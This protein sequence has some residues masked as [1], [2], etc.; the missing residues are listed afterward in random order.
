[1]TTRYFFHLYNGSDVIVDEI[2]VEVS[3]PDRVSEALMQA[4]R[5]MQRE[6]NFNGAEL[7]GWELGVVDSAGTGVMT[8]RL[9]DLNDLWTAMPLAPP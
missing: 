5:E 7:D 2:G 4:M 9:R 8:V 1:M 6:P 3:E